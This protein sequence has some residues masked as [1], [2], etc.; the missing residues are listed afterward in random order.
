MRRSKPT[1]RNIPGDV[2]HNSVL[3]TG[4][5]NRLMRRGKR[6]TGTRVVYRAFD[7][8]TARAK[9]APLGGRKVDVGEAGRRADGRRQ[10][11]RLGDQ[12]PRGNPQDGGGQPRLRPLPLVEKGEARPSGWGPP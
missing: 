4:F 8:I 1:K 2:R 10:Q 7:L 5:V 6:S 11:H 3:V 9:R 12:A